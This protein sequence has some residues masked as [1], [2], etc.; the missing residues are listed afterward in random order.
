MTGS[1]KY[2]SASAKQRIV[3][4]ALVLGACATAKLVKPKTPPLT[5]R[6][7]IGIFKLKVDLSKAGG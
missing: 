3:P 2:Q 5:K 6:G 4:N 1:A 7:L